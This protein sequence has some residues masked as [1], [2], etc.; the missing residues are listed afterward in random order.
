MTDD[1][2]LD[3]IAKI[4]GDS[5]ALAMRYKRE[6]EKYKSLCSQ[7]YQMAGAAGAPERFL[8]ALA[9]ASR[10][11]IGDYD[12]LPVTDD[13]FSNNRTRENIE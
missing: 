3:Y 2:M 10:G 7:V 13:E 11:K 4:S 9:D 1:K 8:D 12:L 6:I 5:F